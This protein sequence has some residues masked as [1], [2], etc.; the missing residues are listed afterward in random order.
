MGADSFI[1]FYGIKFALDPD[2]EDEIDACD[3][4]A[5]ARCVKATQAGLE[6]FTGRMTDGEDYFLYIGR[7][8][9]WLGL[10]HEQ[11]LAQ[12]A[13]QLSSTAADVQAKLTAAGF[14]QAPELHFQFMGQY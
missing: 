9:A 8:V 5:D 13:E 3:E 6:S 10:E 12:S 11:H 7:Q 4:G 2:D 1:A 14:A